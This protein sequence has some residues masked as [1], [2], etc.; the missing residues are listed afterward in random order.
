MGLALTPP[1]PWHKKPQDLGAAAPSLFSASSEE[2]RGKEKGWLSCAPAQGP[3]PRLPGL[4]T[5]WFFCFCGLKSLR[6]RQ[7]NDSG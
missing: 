7:E 2:Q 4:L 5:G 1:S 6:P 3:A